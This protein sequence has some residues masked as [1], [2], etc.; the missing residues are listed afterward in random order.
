MKKLIL[1]ILILASAFCLY[2]QTSLTPENVSVNGNRVELHGIIK[3]DSVSASA[4]H[5]GIVKW[6]SLNYKN[7]KSVIKSDT[8]STIVMEGFI[9]TPFAGGEHIARVVFDIKDGRYRWSI[10]NISTYSEVLAKYGG[11]LK[12][13]IETEPWF[14]ERSGDDLIN[15]IIKRFSDAPIS[16]IQGIN[17]NISDSDW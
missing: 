13:E 12:T 14:T 15:E 10:N 2:A 11:K 5:D 6:I 8:P 16:M 9:N 1:L 7:P 17:L 4:I 3:V